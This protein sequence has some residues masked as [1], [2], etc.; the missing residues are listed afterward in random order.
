M[1]VFSYDWLRSLGAKKVWVACSGSVTSLIVFGAKSGARREGMDDFL[2]GSPL[3][4][5]N[6][7]PSIGGHRGGNSRCF[8]FCLSLEEKRPWYGKN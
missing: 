4:A 5:A 1:C 2:Q 7:K 6:G 3:A 8:V